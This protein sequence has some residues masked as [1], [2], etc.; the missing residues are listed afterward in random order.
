MTRTP[1]SPIAPQTR[2]TRRDA[3]VVAVVGVAYFL[4]F[5]LA[6]LYPEAQRV[7]SAVWP[8]AGVGLASLLLTPRRLWPALAGAMFVVGSAANLSVGMTL[9]ASFGYMTANVAE[10]LGC[11]W[12]ITALCGGQVRFAK[13]REVLA[14]L[15]G[16]TVVNAVTACVGAATGTL[17]SGTPFTVIWKTWFVS[18]GLGLLLVTPL[19][20][21]LAEKARRPVGIRWGGVA[22]YGAFLV[23]WCATEWLAFQPADATHLDF[24]GP[25]LLFA[26]LPWPAY[27]FGRRGIAF[28]LLLVAALCLTA[29]SV[30]VGP[31]ILGGATVAE[32]LL[33][34]QGFLAVL[35]GCGLLMAAS[36]TEAQ[37]ANRASREALDR[38]RALGDNVPEGMVYQVVSDH[39]GTMQFTYVSAGVERI[40]GVT[41]ADVL[42]NYA[43]F[44]DRI[45]EEDRERFRAAREASMGGLRHVHD[46][47][48]IR[49]PDGQVRWIQISSAPRRLADGRTQWDG[50]V[51]DIT[52]RL[53]A[54]EALRESEGKYRVLV[55]MESD[56]LVLVDNA[57]GRILEANAAAT[58]LYGYSRDELLARTNA[59]LSAEPEDTRR[60]TVA[61]PIAPDVLVSIPLRWH[62]KKDGTVFPVEITGRFFTWSGRPVHLAAIRDITARKRAEE[63]LAQS[64][65]V[66]E[67]VQG[68]A[69]LGSWEIDLDA[70]T[71]TASPEA[72]RIY[73]LPDDVMAL[74]AIQGV[75]LPEY[76]P[77]LDAALAALIAEGA[78]YNTEFRIR[79]PTD[80]EVRDIHSVGEYD[81]ERRRVTGFIQDITDRKRAEAENEALQAQLLQSQ[82]IESVG[83]LA[84]GVA[85]DFNNAVQ[86]ILLNTEMALA[87]SATGTP[88]RRYLADIQASAQHSAALTAQLLA[89]ARKQPIRPRVLDLNAVIAELLP[90]LRRLI[91]EDIATL[92]TPGSLGLWRVRIDPTQINQV[93]T[94]LALNA[95][96]AI[97]GVGR[98]SLATDN[99]TV[100]AGLAATHPDLAPGDYVRL[101]VADDGCGMDADTLAH[102]FEPFFTTKRVGAGTG[103]GLATVYGIIRQNAGAVTVE[104]AP[105]HG[106]TFALW[107]PRVEAPDVQPPVPPSVGAP[108]G[109]TETILL[110]E[111]E[112]ALLRA[113]TAILSRLGYAVLA[114]DRPGAAI[115]TAAAHDGPIHLLV[116]DVVMPE[117]NGRALADRLCAARPALLRLYVSGYSGDA[118]GQRGTI[119]VDAPFLA[120]PFNAEDLARKVRAV[121]DGAPAA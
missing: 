76:R 48:R 44:F 54:V 100:D 70:R 4:A 14:L 33:L 62:R 52:E 46:E 66:L 42:K 9:V 31:S 90:L 119:E 12:L 103:L 28:A 25:Y 55:E 20:V 61:T 7:V 67:R 85:H 45:H 113:G 110:V 3:L 29:T 73:G 88:L 80:G 60:V 30:R 2:S 81:A 1:G 38:L 22:E 68:L 51:I 94:N 34:V 15:A 98:L 6:F 47:F 121:L 69:H 75:V 97:A 56:A 106:S 78:P 116:T 87:E 120:K 18:N 107:L 17:T 50:A 101:T 89:F 65:L 83:R 99:A 96:D 39:D 16:A 49:R 43:T 41:A 53:E 24:F 111:D 64:I 93:L 92:W 71:V 27:R 104:S 26:L 8:V 114:A 117:M 74:A 72:H 36:F 79:R 32:R 77:A 95:R 59:S 40:F 35:G 23:A 63:A 5:R 13:V 11:A 84:G 105:G 102:I 118:L 109:G 86:A 108:R 10:S 58:S 91:G 112:A 82:K 115:H 19:V 57:T 21:T 37:R